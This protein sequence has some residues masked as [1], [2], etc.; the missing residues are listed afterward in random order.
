MKWFKRFL[1]LSLSVYVCFLA[2]LYWFQ[3][4]LIFLSAPVNTTHQ[5]HFENPTEDVWLTNSDAIL[6]GVLFKTRD[7]SN[8]G[9]VLYFKGN[10]GNVGHSERL[11]SLFLKLGYDVLSMD[12]RGSGKSR[13]QLSE[14]RLLKDAELWHDWATKKYGHKVRVV[15][16][17]LGTT[18][19]SH[20]AAVRDVSHTIL[21][22]PMWS[23]EE[24]AS[25]RYPFV[26]RFLSR[27]PLRSHEK[28]KQ[29]Q[30]QIVIY[31]GTA[32]KIIPFQSGEALQAVL[33]EDDVFKAIE[34][35]NH[36]N[37]AVR[38]EVVLDIKQR[39][40]NSGVSTQP[41]VQL[42]QPASTGL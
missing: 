23:I 2:G 36:Y 14:E 27:Y 9:V 33:G 42:S 28:L 32:D 31:H 1:V 25:R 5:Y 12:Y 6:N 7:G 16:Y 22:A 3:E 29:A 37:V 8:K 24:I 13:G 41:L 20:I 19:A 18:F 34:G 38:E 26:P 4:K 40:L 30:G 15:G 11:A 17:S 35:A 10:M 39:W 21:F